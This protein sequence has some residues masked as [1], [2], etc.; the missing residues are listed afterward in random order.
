MATNK[1]SDDLEDM[2]FS[3]INEIKQMEVGTKVNV[4]GVIERILKTIEYGSGGNN[5]ITQKRRIWIADDSSESSTIEVILLYILG[6]NF[7]FI[8]F[9]I[10]LLL[11]MPRGQHRAV[12]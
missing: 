3:T 8:A 1:V 11:L 4:T 10:F 6:R 5:G 7:Y 2:T 9:S 12:A